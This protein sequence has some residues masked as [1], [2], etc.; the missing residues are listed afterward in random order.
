M[1]KIIYLFAIITHAVGLRAQPGD[2]HTFFNEKAYTQPF[3][4]CVTDEKHFAQY[5]VD[6][7]Q[8]GFEMTETLKC[9][10]HIPTGINPIWQNIEKSNLHNKGDFDYTTDFWIGVRFNFYVDGTKV[11]T[12]YQIFEK[13]T[14]DRGAFTFHFNLD[15]TNFSESEG[16]IN[17]AYVELL[18]T[19]KTGY[20]QIVVEAA[21]PSKNLVTRS[22][23]PI[24]SGGII[25]HADSAKLDKWK[26]S[27]ANNF[28]AY[29]ARAEEN[30]TPV[31]VD[32][33]LRLK[34]LA[35]ST[36]A[37]IFGNIGFKKHFSMTCLQNPCVKNYMYA[38][39]FTTDNP[40]TT[41]PQSHCKEAIIT[42]EYAKNGVPLK[43]RMLV[44]MKE[45]GD[46]VQIEDNP[47]GRNEI[48]FEKQQILTLDEIKAR[49]E[50]HHPGND[51]SVEG[52]RSPLAYSHARIKQPEIKST[53]TKHSY[54]GYKILRETAEG[55]NWENGF[56]YIA[57][58]TN[59]NKS[60]RLFT[61][62]AVTGKLLW[63][64]EIRNVPS[65]K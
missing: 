16:S 58:S 26:Q 17:Y 3:L 2:D 48:S 23:V 35:D 38:N 5:A 14:I 28:Q 40:C 18:K 11:S 4:H 65:N 46:Y 37:R 55:E 61:F 15:P 8:H 51:L 12:A 39:T 27:E 1:K 41:Q 13:A 29:E 43:I 47:F 42:Y 63:I 21:M 60:N 20:R 45:N 57:H 32:Y 49:I 64:T 50:K 22:F 30:P 19:L 25:L 62:D 59:A 6:A 31:A 33:N 9:K 24:V 36:M 34:H 52:S 53:D 44:T 7:K 56:V 54:P 10:L